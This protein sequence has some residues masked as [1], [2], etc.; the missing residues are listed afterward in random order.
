MQD[1]EN[2][3]KESKRSNLLEAGELYTFFDETF[4]VLFYDEFENEAYEMFRMKKQAIV[5]ERVK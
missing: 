2:E 4:K 5:V 3:K 1:E